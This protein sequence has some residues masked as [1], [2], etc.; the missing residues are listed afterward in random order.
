MEDINLK[1]QLTDLS[2]L[3]ILFLLKKN[4]TLIL[5]CS[6]SL[7]IFTLLISTFL[8]K[9]KYQAKSILIVNSSQPASQT[10]VTAQQ[11]DL[12][13]KL[14]DTYAI[15]I[16]SDPVLEKVI[17]NLNL[18]MTT[19]QLYN[20]VTISGIGTTEVMQLIVSNHDPEV[21]ASIANEIDKVAPE[22]ITSTVKSATVSIISIAKVDNK[23]ISP[24]IL[25]NTLLGFLIGIII[26][27]VIAFIREMLDNT[28]KSEEDIKEILGYNVLGFI[29]AVIEK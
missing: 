28:F 25:L 6:F 29:P 9:P 19:D 12:Y 27:L 15:I 11:I 21:A 22:N 8:I 18:S 5:M 17:A 4:I 10:E 2:I 24:N 26:S 1:S 20:D 3:D 16:K 14:V 23:P 13:Q 7:A